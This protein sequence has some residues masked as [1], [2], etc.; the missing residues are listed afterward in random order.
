MAKKSILT[1]QNTN[2]SVLMEKQQDYFSLTDI[3]K[4][5]NEDNPAS[6]VNNWLRLKDTIEF[7]GTWEILHNPI[8]NLLEFEQVKNEAGTN[9]FSLS[10]GKWTESTG[11]VGLKT[12]AGRHGGGTFVHKDIALAFGIGQ[13]GEFKRSFY[14]R[15]ISARRTFGEAQ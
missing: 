1:V 13:P 8:F 3:A 7:L 11:A 6:I 12:K 2:I 14:Q 4:R 15:R 10:V 5:V 9:R